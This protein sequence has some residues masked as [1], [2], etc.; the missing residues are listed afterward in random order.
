[1]RKLTLAAGL[2]LACAMLGGCNLATQ[3]TSDEQKVFAIMQKIAAGAKVA[4]ADAETASTFVCASLPKISDGLSQVRAVVGT[5]PK[6]TQSLALAAA[7]LAGVTAYCNGTQGSG[8]SILLGAWKGLNAAEAA[9]N[10]A[11]GAAGQ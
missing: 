7:A 5:G 2:A 4:I 11:S 10:S 9:I 6:A 8:L 1:M 3:L